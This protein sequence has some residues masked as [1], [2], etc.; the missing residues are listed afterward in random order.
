MLVPLH[1]ERRPLLLGDGDR[2]DLAVEPPAVDRGD[3]LLLRGQREGVLTLAVHGPALGDVLGGLAHRVR[4]V[5]LGEA[6][7]EEAPAERRVLELARATVERGPGLGHDIRRPGHR[8][9]TAADE[10][11][12]VTDRDRVG[13]RVDR[14]EPGPAQPI[15]RQP[16]DLDRQPGEEEGHPGHVAIV[17]AGLVGAAEDDVLDEGRVDAGA[18][19]DGPDR[20]RRQVV[21]ADRGEGAAVPSDRRPDRGDDPRV[22]Q[23]AMEITGHGT[24]CM[25]RSRAGAGMA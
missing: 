19:D 13:R 1:D 11:V 7:I 18:I 10:H 4:V 3:R 5:E 8:F 15:D 9:D 16:A 25:G 22:A 17:L 24:D 2:H 12:A 23:R 14:L 21:G 20:R 6:R